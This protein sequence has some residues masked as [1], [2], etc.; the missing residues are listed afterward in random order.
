MRTSYL[1]V[2]EFD[3][4]LARLDYRTLHA[5]LSNAYWSPRIGEAEIEK[6]AVNSTLVA[7]C[8][9]RRAGEGHGAQVGYLRL[10]SD[11]TRFAFIMDVYVAQEHRRRGIAENLVL[12]AMSH[13]ELQDVYSWLLGTKDA[14]SV[15]RKV[16][17][18][19]LANPENMMMLKKEKQRP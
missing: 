10:V 1:D 12:F 9:L 2:Y 4:D 8:Y 14:H 19:A 5:W 13:P 7:G 3:D 15:Y 11:K 16:G 6:G 17:F 18:G